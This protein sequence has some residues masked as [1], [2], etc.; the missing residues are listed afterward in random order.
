MT[1]TS[2]FGHAHRAVIATP[3]TLACMTRSLTGP[4]V[5]ERFDSPRA[6]ARRCG[7][8]L[9]RQL[10]AYLC[11]ATRLSEFDSLLVEPAE[12]D[13]VDR[14]LAATSRV[15]AVFAAVNRLS[16]CAPWLR[17]VASKGEPS[18]ARIIRDSA[19][20][21]DAMDDVVRAATAWNDERL[22]PATGHA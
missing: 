4:A 2:Q 16:L 11:G 8:V 18:P 10:T 17:E 22:R 5:D 13:R 1:G 20:D 9:G 15:I 19:E 3:G 7:A 12:A 21:P 6:D 14:R